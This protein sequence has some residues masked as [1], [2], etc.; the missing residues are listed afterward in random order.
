[1][2][3]TDTSSSTFGAGKDPSNLDVALALAAAGLSILPVHV[4]FDKK[5]RKWEKIPRL[6]DWRNNATT[7][8]NKIREWW[9]QWPGSCPGIELEKADLVVIDADRHRF[10]DG[11][12]AL[13][14]LQAKYKEFPSH[15]V[16][17]TAGDGEHHYFKQM[18]GIKLT[19]SDSNLPPGIDVRGAGGLTVAPGSLRADGKRWGGAGLA[20]AFHNN[21]IPHIP[22]WLLLKIRPPEPKQEK[23]S[24]E[25]AKTSGK[26]RGNGHTEWSPAEEAMVRDAL[27]FIPNDDRNKH[28]FV[29]GGAL[30]S[31]GWPNAREIWDEWSRTSDKFNAADQDKTWESYDRPYKGKP[32]TIATLFH[33]AQQHGWQHPGRASDDEASLL[34]EF[35]RDYCVVR[36]GGKTRVLSFERHEQRINARL[37]HT[38]LVPITTSFE[39]FRNFHLNR[40]MAIQ[41]GDRTIRTSAGKWWLEHR[42]RRTYPGLVFEPAGGELVDERLNLWRGWGVEPKSGDWSLMRRHI[43][44][45]LANGVVTHATYILNW[46]AWTVQ[47]P[48]ER[49]EVALAFRGKRGTGRGTLG[50]AMVH[51]FGQHGS[52]LSSSRHVTGNF[53]AH[54][55]DCCFLFAD[56]AFWPGDKAAEGAL[57]RLITE[58]YL[59]IEAKHR[60]IV[61]VL[62]MLHVM[63]ASN[64]EWLIP[65]GEHERRFAGFDVPD[66]YMQDEGWFVPLHNQLDSGGYSAML[67]DL[68]RHPLG[69][70][71]PRRFPKTEMLRDQQALSLSY[72]DTWWVEL[73]ETGVLWGA[74]SDKPNIAMSR[75]MKFEEPYVDEYGNRKTRRREIKG[76]YDQARSSS[77]RLRNYSDHTLGGFLSKKGC[78]PNKHCGPRRSVRGWAFPDL[79]SA[80][81]KWEERFPGWKWRNPD[82]LAWE[83]PDDE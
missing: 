79:D 44:E 31:T 63:F 80:R 18:P 71:H 41:V 24:G 16:C 20:G 68:L 14:E 40:R 29:I 8:P 35:N 76:L 67:Y 54:M 66:T 9:K 25:K 21:T 82:L 30:H 6:D 70:F 23:A 32:A 34:A 38:R 22:D 57:K 56:E 15:P 45:V 1:M 69:D 17:K 81:T 28:W 83:A 64:D 33:L 52:H 61:M 53:N 39:D 65:A 62:N 73:L 7:N 59:A 13:K 19:N 46:L 12:A 27:R 10:E 72:E 5:K 50:N 3:A 55:R 47:H 78:S 26:A 42:D 36:D 51:I 43:E 77:P 4:Y 2:T 37:T 75:G 74:T 11:V 60:D 49:A 48:S 58:P